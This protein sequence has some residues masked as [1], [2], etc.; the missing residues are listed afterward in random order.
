MNSVQDIFELEFV[1]F[2]NQ[3]PFLRPL[4]GDAPTERPT[5]GQMLEFHYRQERHFTEEAGQYEQRADPPDCLQVISTAKFSDNYFYTS[6]G[7]VS[8]IALGGWRRAM[9][10]PSI[11]EFIQVLVLQSVLLIIC[12][13]LE[14]HLGTHGRSKII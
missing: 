3:D 2:D 4:L 9:A 8:V 10:P 6:N 12:P 7:F 14:T 1:P 11:L 13:S 5:S